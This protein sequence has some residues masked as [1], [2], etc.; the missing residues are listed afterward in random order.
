MDYIKRTICL[1]GARTRTQGLMPYYEFGT[2]NNERVYVDED[3]NNGNWGQFVANPIFLHSNGKTYETMLRN[4][5]ALLNMVRN[6]VKLRKVST[7][8]NEII[9][10]EDLGAFSW[11]DTSKCFE[12]GEEPEFLYEYAAYDAKD[13]YSTRIDSVRSETQNVYRT[14][15]T[16]SDEYEYIVLIENYEKFLNLAKY[17]DETDYKDVD[18]KINIEGADEHIK[19]ARYCQVV[20]ICIGRINIPSSIYNKHIK[21]PKSILCVD[22]AEYIDWLE[23]YETLSAD[24]CNARLYEDMGGK[25][26][27]EYLNASAKTKCEEYRNILKEHVR[28]EAPYL[29]MSLNLRQN[30]TDV[31]VLTNIDGVEYERDLKGPSTDEGQTRPHGEFQLSDSGFTEQEEINSFTHNGIGVTID[32]IIMGSD[33]AEK[34]RREYP[35]TEEYESWTE[36]EKEE[37]KT[38]P[39]EVESLLKTLR[40]RKIYTDD[41]NNVLPGLFKKFNN[42]PAGKMFMCIKTENGWIMQDNLQGSITEAINGEG[43]PSNDQKDGGTRY[44]NRDDD[45][46]NISGKLYRTITTCSSGIRIAETEEEE[47]GTPAEIGSHYYFFVKYDNGENGNAQMTIPYKT[48]NATNVYLVSSG[49]SGYMYRGDFIKY[50]GRDESK[51]VIEFE[52]VIGGYFE[53]DSN[54]AFKNYIG[55]GDVYYEKYAYSPNHCDFVALDGV[56]N[57]PIWSEYIDFDSAS[58]EFY[59]PR[60]NLYRTGN[61]A[62]IIAMTT[63]EEW[64]KETSYDAYLTKE[65]YLINFSLPPKVDV[66]VTVDR[67]G[68]SAFEKHYKLTECNT[69]QDLENYNNGEFF[70]EY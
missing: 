38:R 59:S 39:I 49:D 6:G 8:D 54:G 12:G 61:V 45:R 58:R 42:N 19:W 43:L 21:V 27:L 40:D 13:F 69:M 60:Y 34:I 24:C 23:N 29:T 36:E 37:S 5:Y 18:D 44:S 20:D 28:Y 2:G 22:V 26:L 68:L 15:I 66:N 4:Y 10:T 67:G 1:E 50:I 25:D 16:V 65:E 47:T 62:N 7:K 35:T 30:F 46:R 17:L 51:S 56:D 11:D 33:D 9:F 31:G 64:Q 63:G 14:S 57:V 70:P 41:Q 53:G 3:N 32:Q 55:S 48:G 52:Y